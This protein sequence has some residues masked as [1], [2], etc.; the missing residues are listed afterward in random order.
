MTKHLTIRLS[1]L[2]LLL[3][4]TATVRAWSVT[5]VADA[6]V[7]HAYLNNVASGS[8]AD[9]KTDVTAIKLSNYYD[10]ILTDLGLKE[11]ASGQSLYIRWYI[12]NADGTL[13]NIDGKL[14]PA[15]TAK[16]HITDTQCLYWC[17]TLTTTPFNSAN[18]AAI[19][20][21]NYKNAGTVGQKVVALIAKIDNTN[22][23]TTANGAVTAEPAKFQ[24]KY[25]FRLVDQTNARAC[26]ITTDASHLTADQ[27]YFT[28][29]KNATY[30]DIT[31][32][33]ESYKN[34]FSRLYLVDRATGQM[35]ENSQD[36]ITPIKT[37]WPILGAFYKTP[38]GQTFYSRT[39]ATTNPQS[40]RITL[41]AGKTLSDIK[42]V[43]LYSD[44]NT[45]LVAGN[46]VNVNTKYPDYFVAQDPVAW[47]S[48]TEYTYKPY[49]FQ[50]S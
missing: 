47:S 4:H 43:R 23:L 10:K 36:Y 19:L 28:C 39:T 7:A 50:H 8:T 2:L 29:S 27:A 45:G 49:T 14:T 17:S 15:T 3:F 33:C 32:D 22:P 9:T 40:L 35:I 37:D 16:G 20:D 24:L 41:P 12:E 13:A 46:L 26:Y 21:L 5:A 34:N 30:F 31:A 25:S 38:Q 42:V 44:N 6:N 11:N 1:L 18:S 48:V